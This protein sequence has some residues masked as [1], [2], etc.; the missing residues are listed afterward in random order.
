MG[1]RFSEGFPLHPSLYYKADDIQGPCYGQ[2]KS[3]PLPDRQRQ[4]GRAEQIE[5][6]QLLQQ[7]MKI[8]S[9][10]A[11]KKQLIEVEYQGE[12]GTGKG[13][14]QEFYT[15]V[16]TQLQ[17]EDLK[18]W[19]GDSFEASSSELKSSSDVVMATNNNP[20]PAE[21]YVHS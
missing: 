14:I 19:R 21:S 18:M 3:N 10:H 5:R 16:S 1:E 8:I 6:A 13:P 4:D 15:L 12:S 20:E 17:R 11:H 9:E 7:A 2:G